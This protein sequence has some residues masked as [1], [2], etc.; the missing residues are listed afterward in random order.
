MIKN[1]VVSLGSVSSKQWCLHITTIDCS[2]VHASFAIPPLTYLL[3]RNEKSWKV[4]WNSALFLTGFSI[5]VSTLKRLLLLNDDELSSWFWIWTKVG[6]QR[7]K[8]ASQEL[9]TATKN[10]SQKEESVGKSSEEKSVWSKLMSAEMRHGEN[11][12]NKWG[13]RWKNNGE[14]GIA[15]FSDW[16]MS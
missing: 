1:E 11:E 16:E 2:N 13:K 9:F 6:R 15:T 12:K 14:S 4:K 10:E 5:I 7:W 8:N 3:V